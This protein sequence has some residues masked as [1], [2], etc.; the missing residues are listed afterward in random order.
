MINYIDTKLIIQKE[1]Q[2][3]LLVNSIA[4]IISKYK[5]LYCK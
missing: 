1:F 3:F 5:I 2:E 4:Y